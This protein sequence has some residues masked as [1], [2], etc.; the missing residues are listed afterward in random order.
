MNEKTI[1]RLERK[2][3]TTGV[4]LVRKGLLD[5]LATIEQGRLVV[6]DG[7]GQYEFG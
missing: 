4:K 5:K 7:F 2:N 6:T 1:S 3:L